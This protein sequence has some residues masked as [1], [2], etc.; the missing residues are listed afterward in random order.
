MYGLFCE[1]SVYT[2]FP[3]PGSIFPLFAPDKLYS[4]DF[5]MCRPYRNTKIIVTNIGLEVQAIG[6]M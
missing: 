5:V 2:R 1:Y 3:L 6:N 4:S